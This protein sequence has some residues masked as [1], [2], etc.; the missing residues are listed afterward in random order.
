MPK[1]APRLTLRQIDIFLAAA[2]LENF[3]DASKALQISPAAIGQTIADMERTLGENVRLF[4]RGSG[5]SGATLTAAGRLLFD[6]GDRIISEEAA[7]R[8]DI[9]GLGQNQPGAKNV[10]RIAYEPLFEGVIRNAAFS[11]LQGQG[12]TV[13]SGRGFR[14]ETCEADF[15]NISRKVLNS[16]ADIGFAALPRILDDALKAYRLA[17]SPL[18]VVASTEGVFRSK[19]ECNLTELKGR[20]FAL[21][22]RNGSRSDAAL[23]LRE[24]IDDYFQEHNFHPERVVFEGNTI[25]AV[26]DMVRTAFPI[27]ICYA[28]AVRK[29]VVWQAT[30]LTKLK[31]ELVCIPL[32]PAPNRDLTLVALL[33]KGAR[34]SFGAYA[35][36][37]MLMEANNLEPLSLLPEADEPKRLEE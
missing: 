33:K 23:S 27:T 16:D 30:S 35:F 14:A 9:A 22:L 13:S 18:V 29:E 2:R 25:S 17:A 32:V 31:R 26:L 10:V 34:P 19:T 5:Q 36:A 4:E 6:H 11:L 1:A 12:P 20:Y 8:R 24:V 15:Q 21:P 3:R 28:M 37:K 7:V